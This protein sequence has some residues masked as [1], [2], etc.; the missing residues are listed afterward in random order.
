MLFMPLAIVK[1][2]FNDFFKNTFFK[3]ISYI[4]VVFRVAQKLS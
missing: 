3:K 2:Q 4:S 1:C